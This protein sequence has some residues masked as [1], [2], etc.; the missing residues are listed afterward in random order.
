M[1][2]AERDWWLHFVSDG[3]WTD[4]VMDDLTQQNPDSTQP[5]WPLRQG[6]DEI[7]RILL[8]AITG[9]ANYDITKPNGKYYLITFDIYSG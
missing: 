3:T 8:S 7:F 6:C 5:D 2:S 4:F 1:I 9:E